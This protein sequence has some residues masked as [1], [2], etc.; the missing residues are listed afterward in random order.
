MGII[1][2]CSRSRLGWTALVIAL[3]VLT[4]GAQE[5]DRSKTAEKYKWNL[6][7]IYPS[8]AAWRAAKDKLAAELPQLRQFQGKLASSART[9][10]DALD[11]QAALDKELSRLYVYASMLADQDTRES[12]PEGMH[13]EMVQLAAAFSAQASYVEPEILKAD[14][15]K[16]QGF[17]ASEPRLK[18]YKFYL[19]DVARRATH[20]LSD[21]EEK[22]L[23]DSGPLAG[24]P[25]NIF[26]I[27][28]NA[29][30]PYPS[31]TLSDGRTVKVDQAGY[32]ELR[33]L[34]NRADR[35]KVM[36]AFFGA[37]AAFSRTYGTT[38]NGE[39][40]KVA[41]VAKSRKYPSA[42]EA[43]LDGPNIPISVYT[44]LID[45]VNRN[46]PAFHR[47]L[48]LRKRMMGLD[49][50]HY[51]DLYAPLVA[52]VDL[53]YSPEEAQK[54]VLAAVAPL[55]RDYQDTIQRAFD[56]RWID[57]FPNEGKRSG[58]YS[59][60]GA[61]DVHPYMLI[62][63]TGQYND[64]STLAHELGHTMQ[65]YFSNKT[66]PY[67][68]AGYPTFVAEVASTFNESLLIDH[69]LK[70]IK[71]DDTRLSLLGNYL[72]GIKGT[73][74]R[75]TQFA[76][77]ELRMHEMAGKGQPIT[78]DAMAKLYLE[79]TR[80]YYGH[81][82]GVSVVDDY[83]AHEWSYIPHFY[84]DFYVF[85]YATSFTA[86]EALAQKVK[87]GDP[88]ATRRYLTFLSAGG[89]KYP[90]DLLKEAGVDMTTD[91]PLDLTMKEMNRVMDEME[92]I[93]ARGKPTNR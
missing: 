16:I 24:T 18:V 63:Y 92:K 14:Q 33:A 87:S 77:F 62:N 75:Q 71:D 23:A 44:R 64:V 48:A 80:K 17:I 73:V 8:D 30:F 61:Y 12:G 35:E 42:L 26:N 1:S 21:S 90:I 40:Q 2:S 60:G 88:E 82:K 55:G 52:S 59:N 86:S 3:L 58:A 51:Y 15:A 13:Q 22:L 93:L 41:F 9:L 37:L 31:V 36:S 54:H 67:P 7:D 85:Q 49:Q 20:T 46:L 50:L 39:V 84:R 4:A 34:A 45:G 83:V 69:M 79:I 53:K 29:D 78:G 68:L 70:T 89:S 56:Q 38:I 27:L 65:S 81:D 25:A 72:E 57:L 10:A 5:R 47:Y 19:D 32:G 91:E 28:S 74:F 43:V 6:A 76:E 66:Q 11:Q